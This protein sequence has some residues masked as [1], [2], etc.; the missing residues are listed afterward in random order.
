[1]NEILPEIHIKPILPNMNLNFDKYK[2]IKDLKA[3]FVNEFVCII[4][5]D[6]PPTPLPRF[7]KP[8]EKCRDI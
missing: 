7:V 3:Q 1:M 6:H 4:C 5:H 8:S 2:N